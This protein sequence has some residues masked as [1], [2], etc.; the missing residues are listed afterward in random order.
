M[1]A[2]FAGYTSPDHADSIIEYAT[3]NPHDWQHHR[4]IEGKQHKIRAD[5]EKTVLENFALKKE[6]EGLGFRYF[7]ISDFESYEDFKEAVAQFFS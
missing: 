4:I 5:A 2:T 3:N 7:D 1:I 6:A